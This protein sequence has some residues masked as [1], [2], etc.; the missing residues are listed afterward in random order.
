MDQARQWVERAEQMDQTGPGDRVD[1]ASALYTTGDADGAKKLYRELLA[2][3]PNNPRILNDLAWIL[4]EHDKDYDGA[5]K[6]ADAGV[7]T[8][9]DDVVLRHL[10]DTRGTILSKMNRFADARK[11][12]ERLLALSPAP[13]QEAKAHFQLGRI[14]EK[15]GEPAE[16]RQHL[17]RALVLDPQ[18]D[19]F[20]DAERS[21]I[22]RI[23]QGSGI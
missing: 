16:A 23:L 18:N 14:C 4:Q 20:T 7:Q 9:G 2:Q 21:D 11:D 17:E 10:L 5:I 22:S 3:D 12:F 6:L 15:L 13:A 1:L 19:I 8:A